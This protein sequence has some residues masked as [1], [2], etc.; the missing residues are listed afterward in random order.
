MSKTEQI[1]ELYA[2]GLSID[3]IVKQ[4][5]TQKSYVKSVCAKQ[6]SPSPTTE[7]KQE[8][9]EEPVIVVSDETVEIEEESTQQEQEQEQHTVQEPEI[10]KVHKPEPEIEA[11]T[12]EKEQDLRN[13]V[14]TVRKQA[15]ERNHWQPVRYLN[16]LDS[17]LAELETSKVLSTTLHY[18]MLSMFNTLRPHPTSFNQW[19][20]LHTLHTNYEAFY[21]SKVN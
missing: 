14:D 17:Q 18:A 16:L 8:V 7:N 20:Y 9:N 2:Q 10:E 4:V 3:E 19:A 11:I 13:E 1:K 21:N 5:N 12:D 15:Q 6:P